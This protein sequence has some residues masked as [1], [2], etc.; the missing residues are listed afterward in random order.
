MLASEPPANPQHCRDSLREQLFRCYH[1]K[2]LFLAVSPL[3]ALFHH[4]SYSLEAYRKGTTLLIEVGARATHV[5][6]VVKGQAMLHLAKRINVGACD[7]E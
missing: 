7:G 6:P 5:L 4:L 2:S 3:M 1:I